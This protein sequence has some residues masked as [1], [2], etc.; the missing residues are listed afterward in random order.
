MGK[1]GTTKL[2]Y[3]LQKFAVN[4]L[5]RPEFLLVAVT[6]HEGTNNRNREVDLLA[7]V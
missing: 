5:W 2:S 7:Y 3:F 6:P 1:G 4:V